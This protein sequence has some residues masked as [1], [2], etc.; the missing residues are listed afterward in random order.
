MA[1]GSVSQIE[2]IVDRQ[3][4]DKQEGDRQEADRQNLEDG[5]SME[6]SEIAR[7]LKPGEVCGR[8]YVKTVNNHFT[9]IFII[10]YIYHTS[11]L[12]FPY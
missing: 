10:I 3:E 6:P 8:C 2:E 11:I 12:N 1:Q 4:G 7:K 9:P 5:T